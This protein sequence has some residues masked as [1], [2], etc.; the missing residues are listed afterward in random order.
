MCINEPSIFT[1]QASNIARHLQTT[2]HLSYGR[3]IV[4]IKLVS[5]SCFKLVR[6]LERHPNTEG[7]ECLWG[8]TFDK[9]TCG[10]TQKTKLW[11]K[12][13]IQL[14]EDFNLLS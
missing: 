5:D 14:G 7:S 10:Q 3:P 12:S 8:K 2:R 1:N 13:V 6:K 11:G 9:Q 4:R